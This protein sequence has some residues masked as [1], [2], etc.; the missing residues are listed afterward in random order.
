MGTGVEHTASLVT[1]YEDINST[2]RKEVKDKRIMKNRQS[3]TYI[4]K[5]FV[6][7]I[8]F[9]LK[10]YCMTYLYFTTKNIARHVFTNQ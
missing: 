8:I 9:M 4:R 3:E 5:Q 1:R 7:I 6:H 2:R 10:D